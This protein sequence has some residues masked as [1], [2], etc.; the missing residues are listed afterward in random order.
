MQAEREKQRLAIKDVEKAIS[1][2]AHYLNAIEE[3][4]YDVVPGEVF[5]KG[6]IRNYAEFLGLNGPEIV[7][8]Y[9][10]QGKS[11]KN[12]VSITATA[13]L[14]NI[15]E[16]D[17]KLSGEPQKKQK[18]VNKTLDQPLKQ[19]TA[20]LPLKF[21]ALAAAIVIV[22]SGLVWYLYS[23]T[24]TELP[25]QPEVRSVNN[26]VANNAGIA[27][28][29]S[30]TVVQSKPVEVGAVFVE[31]CW[32]IVLVDGKVV[33]EGIPQVGET[34]SW[35]AQQTITLKLGNAGGANITY[36]GKPLGKI[37]KP[38]EVLEKNFTL[39]AKK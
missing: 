32:T 18:P 38:G 1:I 6:F 9:R 5:L 2:R 22:A 3:G 19:S 23:G 37:G 7:D 8:I 17:N 13:E 28:G 21:I 31:D 36:N 34:L 25:K 16:M 27:V 33:Y 4:N 39:A 10:R 24:A 29:N 20:K 30:N 14:P 12:I 15:M 35:E 11:D 26:V